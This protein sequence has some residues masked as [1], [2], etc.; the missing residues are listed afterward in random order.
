[1]VHEPS[2]LGLALDLCP[3]SLICQPLIDK[4]PLLYC[5]WRSQ[6]T[7]MLRSVD[8][9]NPSPNRYTHNKAPAYKA[10]GTLQKS[11]GKDCKRQYQEA[12][13]ETVTLRHG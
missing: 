8:P 5:K 13:Y 3:S 4:L 10:L 7:T 11:W 1:M 2:F 9:G 6:K 12:C